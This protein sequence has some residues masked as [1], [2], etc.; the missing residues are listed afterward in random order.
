[1]SLKNKTIEE[2]YQKLTQREHVLLRAEMYIGSIKKHTEEL[3]VMDLSQNK[4]IKKF[5]EYSPGFLKIVDEAIT[6]SLDHSTR[7]T[8]VTM[9][10]INFSK[11]TGEISVW[12]N[13]NG[14]PS[15]IH[16]DH[17]LY[18]PELIFGQL[19]SG[20]NYSDTDKRIGA[21]QFG[22]G[23]KTTNI[24][25]KK[26]RVETVDSNN[27]KKFIQE[28]YNNMESK[29]QPKITNYM[30]KSYTQISFIPD[31]T[32]F[33]M[34]QLE[35]DT[36]LLLNKRVYD[37]IACTR[38]DIV[39]YLNGEKLKGKTFTDYTKYFFDD[40]KLISE[41]IV[42]KINDIEYI[43]EYAVIPYSHY[44]QIS[45]VNGNATTQGGKHVDYILYQITTKIKELLETKKKLKDI[46]P[47]YIKERLFLF[48]KATIVNPSFNSQTKELLT[49][50]SK[51]F[52]CKIDVSEAFIN[53]I[54]KSQIVDEIVDFCKIKEKTN[55]G[56][57]TDGK[58]TNKIY[59]EKLEDAIWAGGPKSN[60]CTLILTEGL[61]AM[62]FAMWGRGEIG[63]DKIGVFPLKG[64]L[65]NVKNATAKQLLENDEINSIKQILGL[66]HNINYTDTNQLRYGKVMLLTDSDVDGSH[67]KS[68]FICF[69]HTFWPS[70]LK[71]N[72]NF[73]QT[74]RT[75]IVKAIKGKQVLEFF[76]EQDYH[77]WKE[78]CK[79]NNSYKIRYFKGLGTSK[80]EDAKETFKR[81][82]ELKID[83]YY[84]DEKCNEAINLAFEKDKNNKNIKN[85]IDDNMSISSENTIIKCTDQRKDWLKKYDKNSY[86]Q[87]TETKVSF[88]DLIHKELIHFSI[89]DNQRSIPSLCDGLKPSQRKILYY[90]LKKN[91]SD[92][93]KVA[94]LSGYVSAETGY[95][96]GEASLQ[97]AI[98]T[99]AQ[100]FIGTNNINL[101]QPEGNYGSR[102]ANNDAA[103][104]RYIY[105]KLNDV[106]KI[107]FNKDDFPLFTYLNDD[108]L[109]I[110]P[111]WY[112]PI[113]PLVL[114]NGCE[115]IGTGYST[116]IPPYNPKDVITNILRLMDKQKPYKMTPY[117]KD[118]NGIVEEKENSE[119]MFII[120]GLW[121][122]LSDT[123]IK[124]TEL[125][126]G[127]CVLTYKEFL[128]SHIQGKSTTTK[129]TKK[130]TKKKFILKDVQ[131]R[132]TDENTDINFI[133]EF[134]DSKTLDLL[135]S[136]GTLEKDLKLIKS[137]N[138]N[139][140]HLFNKDLILT[141]YTNPNIIL[142]EFY[143][144]RL[145]YYEKRR[146]YLINKLEEEL[147][148]LRSK[149]RFI[150]EYINNTL[151]IN[152]KSKDYI[153]KLLE[154]REYLKIEDSYDYLIKMPVI[155]MSLE[156][157]QELILQ[158]KNKEE[159]LLDLQSK[160]NKDL[161][162]NDLRDLLLLLK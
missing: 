132:T 119:G 51:D 39:V 161:W 140:M 154:E 125:P 66:R 152:K 3:W 99:M 60:A 67:I 58:K 128:E 95:H 89:Y 130:T 98:I 16:K 19:L 52:G 74:L 49:T 126:I 85:N 11:E 148:V 151:D 61:S 28:Y 144:L 27:N 82:N 137:I 139:N 31:Y 83:Y 118:F 47:S 155:S 57:K 115:G 56:K 84:K 4:M 15:E 23:I 75:P 35:D 134:D 100:N 63:P 102:L 158:I 6:N 46:K 12:N 156:K 112:L 101:L 72:P 106:T 14:I 145:E 55:I 97:Q 64:K 96:H 120:K 42:Q 76:T 142:I 117:Y 38:K 79:N 65:L 121:E 71:I 123:Q 29:T 40:S 34:N 103:S 7:D 109:D 59:I 48:L 91:I 2:T 129:E 104:P 135:I 146:L 68:L 17:Q 62:T 22:I 141:K 108:G 77:K 147:K 1:M 9:I 30:G 111:E 138:T 45:F 81:M 73:I 110:E 86:I 157:I 149:A 50:Q 54:Y 162:K 105:T 136:S 36:I 69:I 87:T 10:K 44:E 37:L 113:I 25:S 43:W 21:G 24:Y 92:L 20:S 150:T 78:S 122:R 127:M 41:S 26:F 93:I 153:L 8:D 80:K 33:S 32:R 160:T 114:I 18:V 143:I 107:L 159:S 131:N 70:L 116:C 94:Q 53:K 90:M 124:I 133:I 13:G 5:V 88:Q